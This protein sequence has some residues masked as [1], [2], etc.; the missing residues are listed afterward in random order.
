M[1]SFVH[2]TMPGAEIK[3]DF[4][5]V[6]VIFSKIKALHLLKSFNKLALLTV[7]CNTAYYLPASICL[8]LCCEISH[9]PVDGF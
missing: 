4:L 5:A 1:F 8:S 9:E 7:L 2:L 6:L 3:T